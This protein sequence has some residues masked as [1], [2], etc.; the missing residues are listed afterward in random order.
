M[1]AG[2]HQ[3]IRH[4]ERFRVFAPAL[5]SRTHLRMARPVPPPRQGLGT[6]HRKL[7]LL[8][9]HREHP[10]AHPQNLKTFNSLNNF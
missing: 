1:K 5:G 2:D 7:N 8:G 9:N 10:H 6:L 3:A 4:R